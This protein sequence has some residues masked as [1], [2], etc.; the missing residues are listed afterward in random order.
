MVAYR[1][2]VNE[3]IPNQITGSKKLVNTAF[4]KSC[5]NNLFVRLG[6]VPVSQIKGGNLFMHLYCPAVVLL[7][8][9]AKRTAISR[10]NLAK[11]KYFIIDHF[12]NNGSKRM[13][14]LCTDTG[15][16]LTEGAGHA[17]VS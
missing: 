6:V 7:T 15:L 3:I 5:P 8:K 11:I 13:M 12:N 10:V 4:P 17:C 16:C 9:I 2:R 1:V 14:E